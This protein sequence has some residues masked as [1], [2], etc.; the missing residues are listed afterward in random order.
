MGRVGAS[1]LDDLK[2]HCLAYYLVLDQSAAALVSPHGLYTE[3][4]MDPAATNVEAAKYARDQLVPRHFEYLTRGYWLMD[5]GQTAA[6]ISYFVDPSVIADW[7]PKILRTA[8]ASGAYHEAAQLLT[9]ATALVHPR[10]DEQISE[11]PVVMDVLLH[12]SFARAFAFQRQFASTPELR[13]ALLAQ[14]CVFAL[15]THSRR[16]VADRLASLP[17]DSIEEAALEEHCLDAGAPAYVKDFLALHYVN[18]G[19]Y[20]EAIRLFRAIATAEEGMSLSD[21]Q[22]RKRDERL[23]MVQSLTML[24][25]AAQRWLV[26]EL[27][28]SGDARDDCRETSKRV[29]DSDLGRLRTMDIDATPPHDFTAT[30]AADDDE[31]DDDVAQTGTKA[32]A[33]LLAAQ[34]MAP[35]SASK[36]ARLQRPIVGTHG[37]LQS[38]SH[39]LLRVLVKQMSA[40]SASVVPGTHST[41]K[42]AQKELST[43]EQSVMELTT[44]KT[45]V[46]AT[47]TPGTATSKTPKPAGSTPIRIPFSGPPSTPRHAQAQGEQQATPSKPTLLSNANQTPGHSAIATSDMAETPLIANRV[48]GG[49]STPPGA[50]RSPFEIA[51]LMSTPLHGA[52]DD[53]H[54][55]RYN[56]RHRAE[57]QANED[58]KLIKGTPHPRAKKSKAAQLNRQAAGQVESTSELAA[59]SKRSA[60]SYERSAATPK[61]QSSRTRK[62]E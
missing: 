21:V 29:A 42:L 58:R 25:P 49:F 47:S 18:R 32:S 30:A 53:D 8:V 51:K 11:A 10:L 27:E 54:S 26:Q 43:S 38:S 7:A 44:P 34:L 17:L 37:M 57:G 22:R 31:D 16:S 41:P 6:S 59:S 36:S 56:L 1:D 15:S 48:P 4:N 28:S 20:A 13:R 19:R 50:S 24:L 55:K 14:M 60:S 2:R 33:A 45:K 3:S 5:H 62:R 46:P 9:S 35:L 39:P 61:Q 40:A 23:A 52:R 12:C